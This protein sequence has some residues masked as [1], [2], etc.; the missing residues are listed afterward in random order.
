MNDR[1]D[2][3]ADADAEVGGTSPCR[4]QL[5]RVPAFAEPLDV[6]VLAG[7][8]DAEAVEQVE[9]LGLIQVRA[10]GRRVEARLA[11]P[12]YGELERSRCGTV[13]AR[14][15]RGQIAAALA[16]TGARRA[17]DLLR[18]AALHLDSDLAPD[19][20]MLTAA[21]EQAF[22]LGEPGL[23][24]RMATAA[25]PGP[26]ARLVRAHALPELGRHAEAAAELEALQSLV[27]SDSE[28][29]RAANL[30]A[31]VRFWGLALPVEARSA[32]E[33][34]LAAVTDAGWRAVLVTC[35]A[36]MD[37][38]LG[39]PGPAATAALSM[40][41][42]PMPHQMG[43]TMA[44]WALLTA[45]GSTGRL[46]GLSEAVAALDARGLDGPPLYPRIAGIGNAWTRALRLAGLLDHQRPHRDHGV[47]RPGARSRLWVPT[48]VSRL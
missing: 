2:A 44:C 35:R 45:R 47:T 11:H 48:S 18:R 31:A 14:R 7:L 20:G 5:R 37:A 32:V 9:A 29:A 28:R 3:D 24:E 39:H 27:R 1:A 22:Q 17:D 19:P 6:P 25:G 41:A 30:L 21:T 15:L 10:D 38:I 13:R 43:C 40:L 42:Q 16:A 4:P 8:T 26:N 46:D 36:L 23:A 33:V 12:L 34:A